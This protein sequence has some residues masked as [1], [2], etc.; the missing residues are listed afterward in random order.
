VTS[1]YPA[2]EAANASHYI[3]ISIM[4]KDYYQTGSA[5]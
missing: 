2:D 4:D 5:L 1:F 3:N